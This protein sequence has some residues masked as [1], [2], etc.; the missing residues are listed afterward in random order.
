MMPS[1]LPRDEAARLDALHHYNVLD[2]PS[3][4]D[5]DEITELAAHFC[6]TPIALICL[7][8]RDRQWFKS[9]VGLEVSETA[10][11]VAFCAHTILQSDLLVV[12]DALQDSRF[13]NNPLVTSDPKIRFYAGMPLITPQ[14]YPIGTLCVIDRIPR[15]LTAEQSRF[16]RVLASQV[17]TQLELRRHLS[18]SSQM[19]ARLQQSEQALQLARA[20]LEIQVKDRTEQLLQSN[21]TLRK[22]AERD[23]LLGAIAARIRQSL[24]LDEILETAVAEVRNFLQV[25]RTVLYQ[26]EV[27]RGGKFVVESVAPHCLSILGDPLHDPC[28]DADYATQYQ[29]GRISAIAD[30]YQANLSPCYLELLAPLQL[31]AML[32][33]PIVFNNQLWG[34]L[35]AHQCSEPRDWQPFEIDLL[36]Q[37]GTQMAIAIQQAQLFQQVKQQAQREQLLNQI[38][39]TLNSSLDLAY[40]LQQIVNH[41]GQCFSVDRAL[42]FAIAAQEVQVLS[43]WNAQSQAQ[44]VKGA[45]TI[46]SQCP[47]LLNSIAAFGDR[48]VFHVPN[49]AS[50]SSKTLSVLSVPIFV[51]NKLAGGLCLHMTTSC[52]TFTVEEIDLLERIA[53]QA[54]I[55]L[56]NAQSYKRLEQ[57]VQKRTQALEQEKL[58]SESANRAK[59][60]FLANMSHELRTPL[61]SIMGL[62]QLLQQEFFGPL[63]DKQQEYVTCIHSSGEHLLSLI[64][65]ILDLAK[66]EAGKEELSF[67]SLCVQEVCNSCLSLVRERAYDRGLQLTTHLDPNANFC[68]ADVRRLKQILLNLLSNAIKFT[69]SGKVSLIVQKQP[70]GITFT[71]ADTGIGIAEKKLPLL[72]QPFSQVDSQL[73]RRYEGTGLG[74]VLARNLAK[75]HGG[76]IT[77]K[78][79]AGKGSQFTLYLPDEPPGLLQFQPAMPSDVS[80]RSTEA[81]SSVRSMHPAQ[82]QGRILVVEDDQNSALLLQD[83]LSALGYQVMHSTDS[84]RFL[85]DIQAVNP[86]LIL[87]DVQLPNGVTGLDLLA[88][89][90]QNPK[91][92]HLPVVMITAMAMRGDRERCLAVGA[93]DYLSKPIQT[94]QLKSLLTQYL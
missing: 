71:I 21:Q 91:W 77:V 78:S 72:F 66:V 53:D 82:D 29:Q 16:L 83:F 20:D 65:D 50:L 68:M 37:L 60:E 42:I 84:T 13:A 30:I 40:V 94:D 58:I 23:R 6:D 11:Q 14:G 5:F 36:R 2:T 35:C 93:T 87:L 10:R 48:Q 79:I 17:I 41:T 33:V 9:K 86:D 43:E 75:L 1:P 76:D 7:V 45:R 39:R 26:I 69:P 49:F 38:S 81:D 32:L 88:T 28:F 27:D 19:V 62:S 92:Q 54:A 59:S 12:E 44:S 64:N 34:L 73:N 31:R 63:N 47:D 24:D 80:V 22:Q 46:A 74:L 52:R 57:L 18:A 51:H 90:R 56:Y 55:A 3:E 70:H 25:E 4:S 89:L 67:T 61:N 15:Q 8:D 85:E